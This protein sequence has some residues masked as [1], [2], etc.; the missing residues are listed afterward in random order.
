MKKEQSFSFGLIAITLLG[1]LCVVGGVAFLRLQITSSGEGRIAAQSEH[2]LYAPRAARIADLLVEPGQVTRKGES[3]VVLVAPQ[4]E[5]EISHVAGELDKV[6]FERQSALINLKEVEITG[7]MPEALI[8]E[9]TLLLHEEIARAYQEMEDIYGGEVVTRLE[10]TRV[11]I[12]SARARLAKAESRRL[13]ALKK[14]GLPEVM[15]ER[16][17]MRLEIAETRLARLEKYLELLEAERAALVI[18]SP[19]DGIVSDLYTRHLGM[20]LEAGEAILTLIQPADGYE[21]VATIKDRNIDLVE[22]G[23]PVRLESR[24]YASNEEGYMWGTVQ[25][26]VKDTRSARAA[27]FE[28]TIAIDEYPFAPVIGSAVDFEILITDANPLRALLNKPE[29]SNETETKLD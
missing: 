20:Q 1:A 27:G 28:V 2:I 12:E 25:Q 10:K 8:V 16:Q 5:V 23:M 4:L 22:V 21:V 15:V 19:V 26:I 29:R 6:R 3:L 24:V 17:K 13:L 14:S 7:G 9:D 18:A 11:T